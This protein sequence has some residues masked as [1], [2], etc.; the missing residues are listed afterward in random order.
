MGEAAGATDASSA[1]EELS[2]AP[3]A[4]RDGFGDASA[5]SSLAATPAPP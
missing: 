1:V 5:S 2:S 3:A 4:G